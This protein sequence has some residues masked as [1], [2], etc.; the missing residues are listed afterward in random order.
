MRGRP[1]PQITMLTFVDPEERVPPDHPLRAI[2]SLAD[3]ALAELSPTFDAMYAEAG[4]PSIPPER[5]LKAS[6][7]IALYSV[8][9]ERAFCEELDYNLL[10]R[11]FLDMDLLEPSFD[12]T[13]FTKNREPLAQYKVA[14]ERDQKGLK[15]VTEP[16]LFET[17][18]RSPQL[19]LWELGPE[20]WH[21]VLRLPEYAPRRRPMSTA[22]QLPLLPQAAAPT[23]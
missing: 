18:F 14:Y 22:V 8:R 9:S 17:Q 23:E 3:R 15:T 20:D 6:L 1:D 12:P 21:L 5:L 4:R 2:K 13:V 16:R 7:L 11:W 19:E 10:F